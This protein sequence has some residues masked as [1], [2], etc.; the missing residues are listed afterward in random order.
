M[1]LITPREASIQAA[2]TITS[3][4]MYPDTRIIPYPPIF[5]S[6]PASMTLTAVGAS[7]C[8]SG[9]HVWNGHTGNFTAKATNSSE[10]ITA[11]GAISSPPA[12]ALGSAVMSKVPV[13]KK[14]ARIPTSM[15]ALPRK[16]NIRNFI[17]E[18]SLRPLPQTAIR[19]Y[20][21]TSSI[22]QKRKK[23][24]K[25]SAVKTPITAVCRTRS[26]MKYS[27]TRCFTLHEA[28][29]A[30]APMRPVSSTIGALRPSTPRKYCIWAS[31]VA[32]RSANGIQDSVLSTSCVPPRPRSY[33]TNMRMLSRRLTTTAAPATTRVWVSVRARTSMISAP[34]RGVNTTA[35][36]QPENSKSDPYLNRK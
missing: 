35:V 19:K 21:G 17:A 26:Q 11:A 9:S 24:R 18:Y 14:S 5:S 13:E 1:T 27:R 2:S 6:T 29:T 22:S 15:N 31:P 33:R 3:G 32:V 16:V 4:N 20:I 30:A 12:I 7:V 28:K 34:A 10:K 23:S 25:S 8:A 36:S